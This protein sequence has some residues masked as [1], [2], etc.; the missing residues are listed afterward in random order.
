[1]SNNPDHWYGSGFGDT[2]LFRG[3][4]RWLPDAHT[5]GKN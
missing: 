3:L 2:T 4:H 5:E 1:M